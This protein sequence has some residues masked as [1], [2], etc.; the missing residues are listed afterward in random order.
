MLSASCWLSNMLRD[1][2]EDEDEDEDGEGELLNKP[3][4]RGIFFFCAYYLRSS[5]IRSGC[6]WGT[7]YFLGFIKVMGLCSPEVC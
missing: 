3:G 4:A 5:E 6:R 7:K 1:R 2:D